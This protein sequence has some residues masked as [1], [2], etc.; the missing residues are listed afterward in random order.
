MDAKKA[1]GY[2][3]ADVPDEAELQKTKGRGLNG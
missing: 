1:A 2:F 3:T